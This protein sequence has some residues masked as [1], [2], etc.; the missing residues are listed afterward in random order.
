MRHFKDHSLIAL[1]NLCLPAV[2]IGC[3]TSSDPTS[4]PA[5]VQPDREK[6]ATSPRPSAARTSRF[7]GDSKALQEALPITAVD[8]RPKTVA[9]APERPP[10]ELVRKLMNQPSPRRCS[11][12]L[13][14][15]IGSDGLVKYAEVL[16]TDN[17]EWALHALLTQK[18]ARYQPA[19][20]NGLPVACVWETPVLLELP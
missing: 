7:W 4:S 20:K 19:R 14:L 16:S 3:S 9:S 8:E 6:T 13:K 2:L 1:V 10:I 15:V 5:R 17:A 12:D 18:K 11:C